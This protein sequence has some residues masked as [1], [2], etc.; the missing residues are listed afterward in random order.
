M[1]LLRN[2]LGLFG[3]MKHIG[4]SNRI[5][6]EGFVPFPEKRNPNRMRQRVNELE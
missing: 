4:I 3:W 6:I 5:A 1:G 2:R